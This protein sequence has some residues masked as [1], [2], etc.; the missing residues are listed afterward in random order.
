VGG[1]KIEYTVYEIK[2]TW[3]RFNG[4]GNIT[5]FSL[6]FYYFRV[7]GSAGMLTA[8]THQCNAYLPKVAPLILALGLLNG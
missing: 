7:L 1:T 6:E 8:M 2:F 4:K 5:K 3:S